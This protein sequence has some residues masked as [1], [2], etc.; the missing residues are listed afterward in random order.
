[1]YD[2]IEPADPV[3]PAEW[4]A[5]VDD[6]RQIIAEARRKAIRKQRWRVVGATFCL[7]AAVLV[8]AW[9]S[10]DYSP[11]MVIA[12]FW[13]GGAYLFA[14]NHGRNVQYVE[15]LGELLEEFNHE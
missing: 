10:D 4:P 3:T 8:G 1:M 12:G 6:G 13:A 14:E 15:T 7:L 2:P 5:P 9:W 11:A